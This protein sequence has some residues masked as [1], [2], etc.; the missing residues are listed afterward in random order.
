MAEEDQQA[1][2]GGI[3]DQVLPIVLLFGLAVTQPILD[4]VGRNPEF[5]IAHESPASDIWLVG[6][7]LCVGAPLLASIPAA[8]AWVISPPVARTIRSVIVAVL[9]MILGM[10]LLKRVEPATTFT[11]L[12]GAIIGAT[13]AFA[14]DRGRQA[15]RL[16]R[17]AGMLVPILLLVGFVVLSP[18]SRLLEGS[19]PPPASAPV[20]KPSNLVMVV[21]DEFPVATLMDRKGRIDRELFPNFHR[22]AQVSTWYRNA[23]A[24]AAHTQW[25]MPA[26]LDG[27]YRQGE[28]ATVADH[29]KNVF[30]LLSDDYE[31]YALERFTQLCPEDACKHLGLR[32]TV[33]QRWRS[34]VADLRV[35]GLHLMLPP[36]LVRDLPAIDEGW[37]DF[38]GADPEKPPRFKSDPRVDFGRFYRTLKGA[39]DRQMFFLHALLPHIPFRFLPSGQKYLRSK[40]IPGREVVQPSRWGRDEWL[41]IQG[42]QRHV[43]QTQYTDRLIGRLLDRLEEE[44]L[45]DRS[46]IVVT[47]D[48]GGAHEPGKATRTATME[49]LSEIAPVPLFIK[50]SGQRRGKVSDVPAQAVDVVPTIA[51]LL[52]VRIWRSA[53]GRSLLRDIP[54]TRRR[55][56]FNGERTLEFDTQDIDIQAIVNRKYEWLS[57]DGISIDPFNL[58]PSGFWELIGTQGPEGA[59]RQQGN[60]QLL[61][62][63]KFTNLDPGTDSLPAL[64]MARYD[65][66][67][68]DERSTI[69][70]Q[71]NGTIRTVTQTYEEAGETRF[72]AMLDPAWLRAGGNRF[73]FFRVLSG[74]GADV[75]LGEIPSGR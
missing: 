31:I 5:F 67:A 43:L 35:I 55:R 28:L 56:I 45:L 68:P 58:A 65:D 29:P 10:Q 48:H 7:G 26:L 36:G 2:S 42:Y 71:I 8:V 66:G 15:R 11:F 61:D 59:P 22:L 49:T 23:T 51:D 60:V 64:M 44:D 32:Q 34:L 75:Q 33:G 50:A 9:G 38:Q 70:V 47:A 6:L 57:G 19:D 74:G 4:L 14:V 72:Y 17:W 12:G 63:D 40:P 13:I 62:A 41:T 52:D 53:E 46:V 25:A 18:T 54:P 16:V 3:W 69:A 30:T 21:L 24:V 20:A 73:R 27:H 1:P 39:D 37:A